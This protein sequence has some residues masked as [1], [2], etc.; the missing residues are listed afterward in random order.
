VRACLCISKIAECCDLQDNLKAT[1]KNTENLSLKIYNFSTMYY[2][3]LHRELYK[4]LHKS[5]GT[6][7]AAL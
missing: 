4:E 2:I 7:A 1:G 3:R 6:E 5:K